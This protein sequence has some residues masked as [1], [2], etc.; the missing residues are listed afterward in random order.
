MLINGVKTT[1]FNANWRFLKP[2]Q[3]ESFNLSSPQAIAAMKVNTLFI[4]AKYRDY[5]DLY[6]LVKELFTLRDIYTYSKDIVEGISFKLFA[7]ALV[8]IDDIDDDN[9]FHL[10]PKED[11]KKEAIRDFF[12]QHLRGY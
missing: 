7:V 10:D 12:E 9:I 5:Y 2:D 4:R 8:Y 3:V 11:I 6:F 1:F